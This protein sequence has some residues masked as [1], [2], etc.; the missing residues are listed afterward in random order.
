MLS[1]TALCGA[2][3][4][5]CG[6]L[7]LHRRKGDGRL[8]KPGHGMKLFKSRGCVVQSAVG[9]TVGGEAVCA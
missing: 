6:F 2:S 5:H 3:R 7:Q 9:R 8:L 1:I 4:Q